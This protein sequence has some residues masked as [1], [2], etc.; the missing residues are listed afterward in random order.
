MWASSRRAWQ[1]TRQTCGGKGSIGQAFLAATS[2]EKNQDLQGDAGILL[3]YQT[4]SMVVVLRL[5]SKEPVL[6]L[7][8]H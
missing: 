4:M 6:G 2:N 5:F 8:D 1:D 7:L 3:E